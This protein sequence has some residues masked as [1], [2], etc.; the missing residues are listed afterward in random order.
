MID[1][2]GMYG[3]VVAWMLAAAFLT[4]RAMLLLHPG[5]RRW[6]ASKDIGYA[7]GLEQ[8]RAHRAAETRK[9]LEYFGLN[10]E[11]ERE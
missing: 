4:Y 10:K 2:V 6:R 9:W 3:S 1:W 11:T 5:V 7:H 8:F